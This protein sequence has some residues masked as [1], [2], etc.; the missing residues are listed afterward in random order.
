MVFQKRKKEKK[1]KKNPRMLWPPPRQIW[2][3]CAQFL[4]FNPFV[5]LSQLCQSHRGLFPHCVIRDRGSRKRRQKKKKKK[6]REEKHQPDSSY[7][8]AAKMHKNYINSW[9]PQPSP[10]ICILSAP[11]GISF[12]LVIIRRHIS[13]D[14]LAA[15]QRMIWG[16]AGC[17]NS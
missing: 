4:I 7:S 14:T 12:F 6:G 10:H 16:W 1:R 5:F 11:S 8:G 2:C 15:G 17:C 13:E 3:V 9:L